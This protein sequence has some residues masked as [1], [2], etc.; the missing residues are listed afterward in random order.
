MDRNLA[1]V[2]GCKETPV[3]TTS[4]TPLEFG[5]TLHLQNKLHLLTLLFTD[6]NFRLHSFLSLLMGPHGGCKSARPTKPILV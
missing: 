6:E 1:S 5:N 2:T 4:V 3:T